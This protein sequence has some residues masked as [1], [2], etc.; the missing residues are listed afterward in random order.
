[1][2]GIGISELLMLAVIGVVV[3]LP[4]WKIFAKAGFPGA[5]SLTQIVPI[6]NIIVLFYLAFAEWPV[7]RQLTQVRQGPGTEAT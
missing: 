1:M 6:L 7:H 3:I 4:F 5:L 2:F